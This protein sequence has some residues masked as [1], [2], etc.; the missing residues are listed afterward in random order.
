MINIDNKSHCCGCEACKQVCPK[1]CISM[2]KD[3]EGFLYPEINISECI[4][5][6]LCEKVCPFH[7]KIQE[8]IPLNVYAAK[9]NNE[10]MRL[11]SSSGGIFTPIAESIISKGGIVFG[12]AFDENWNVYHTYTDTIEGLSKFRGSKYVQSRIG[13]SFVKAK[14]FLQNNKIVLFTGTPCQ[15]AGL[16]RFLKKDYPD[17]FTVDVK[18]HGVPSPKVWQ[19]YIKERNGGKSTDSIKNIEFRN[20]KYGWYDYQ[21]TM[22][23]P[24]GTYKCSNQKDA[25]FKGFL[26]HLCIRPSCYLCKYKNGSSYSDITLADF[27]NIKKVFPYFDDNKGISCIIINSEKG[28]LL[29]NKIKNHIQLEETTYDACEGWLKDYQV[30]TERKFFFEKLESKKNKIS[31]LIIDYTRPSLIFTLKRTIKRFL[32][33][34][35]NSDSNMF[36]IDSPGQTCNRF[37][38]Y[39]DT[40]GY[41]IKNNK[42]VYIASWDP[43]IKYYDNLR[44][45]KY[46]SFP[47][48]SQFGIQ[49]LGEK[50]YLRLAKK[51][52][53]NKISRKIYHILNIEM[54]NGWEYRASYKYFPFEEEKIKKIYRPNLN[55][56]KDVES[57]FSDY[58]KDGYF[59]IGVHIRR[60]DYKE[61]ENG[62]YY[63]ELNEYALQM[64]ELLKI[65]PEKKVI[66]FISTNESDLGN[67]F[68][69]I[70]TFKIENA[71]VAH[72]L[73]ALSMCDRIIGPLSTFSRWASFY[74][75]V[76]LRFIERNKLIKSDS[77]FSVIHS[78]YQFQNGN[79]IPNLTDK[80]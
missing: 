60:G 31:Q 2:H 6:N 49:L 68:E 9:N 76:P 67:Y 41:A 11:K 19:Y 43:S 35:L 29:L 24:Y 13:D 39:L 55:I 53:T 52:A 12:A 51:L 18:C 42:K 72:D 22:E 50:K 78:F 26:E 32:T 17:L 80:V 54:I 23:S 71:T 40:I 62:K 64:A 36:I 56:C 44:K 34:L 5:C 79:K 74:G 3:N 37:W 59:I 61:W 25:F 58:K 8:R 4:R 47:L 46:T 45:S 38:S 70:N 57:I 21:F 75:N 48:Y 28:K 16:K 66:F 10:E 27:W 7:N 63:F 65:Y 73:Y 14:E 77:E 1:A 30:P 20:K 15:I 33:S 69:D